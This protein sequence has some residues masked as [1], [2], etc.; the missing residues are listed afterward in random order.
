MMILKTEQE[1]EKIA[2]ANQ[3]V[4]S[5]LQLAID[6]VG[7]EDSVT[8]LFLDELAEL[9]ARDNGA[10]PAF[11][12]YKGF[13]YSICSSVNSEVVHG[14]PSNKPLQDGDILSIDFGILLDGYYGDSAIT[15]PVGRVSKE[16]ESLIKVGQECLYK[17]IKQICEG[18]RLNQISHAVQQHAESNGYGVVRKFV[19]HGIGRNLHELPQVPNFTKKPNEGILLKRGVVLAIEPMIVEGSYDLITEP[20]GWTTRTKDGKL[21]VHWEHTVAITESGTKILSLREDE[22]DV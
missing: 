21:A 7:C 13:P 4:A 2:K 22:V 10:T 6:V 14:M 1:I 9:F 18:T 11:K 8:T 20:D 5:Y 17:G 19:G 16:A 12:G 15:I 3:L